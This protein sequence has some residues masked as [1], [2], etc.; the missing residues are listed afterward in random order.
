VWLLLAAASAAAYGAAD[1]LGGLATRR[2]PVI[3]VIVTSQVC[4]LAL[5]LAAAPLLG[6]KGL[7]APDLLWGAAAG[8][9]G[10]AGLA[11]FYRAL[12][13]TVIGIASPAAAV[14]GAAFPVS[15]G[16]VLGDRP[17]SWGWAGLCV[18][19]VAILALSVS[20]S[21]RGVG[22]DPRARRALLLGV[23]AGLGFGGFF[24]LVSRT[25]AGSGLWPLVAARVA[26]VSCL[27][28]ASVVLRRPLG[29]G[30]GAWGTAVGAGLL[31]MA[32]NVLYLLAQ[33]R[34]M[35]ALA[36]VVVSLYAA[37]TVLLA[38]VVLR[39]RVTATRWAGL[40]LAVCAVALMGVP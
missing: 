7:R 39:E 12:A 33:R 8:L 26:S 13:G 16:I 21:A 38:R 24:V 18:A 22:R 11:V 23:G 6:W 32:A 5:A 34:G 31:D 40:A 25:A 3:A 2:A 28:V 14:V 17:S 37:P 9:A 10:A 36:A 1:F 27:S 4:G 30:R 19:L 35:L 15:F 29:V 20:A